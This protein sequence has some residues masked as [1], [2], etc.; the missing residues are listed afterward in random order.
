MA[1]IS[2]PTC[3]KHIDKKTSYRKLVPFTDFVNVV[4]QPSHRCD[5]DSC[6]VFRHNF[7]KFFS[8]E[9]RILVIG[10]RVFICQ[11][12]SLFVGFMHIECTEYCT[13]DRQELLGRYP[14]HDCKQ[15]ECE[16]Y[17]K[18]DDVGYADWCFHIKKVMRYL[19][20]LLRLSQEI[21]SAFDCQNPLH[22]HPRKIS[23]IYQAQQ[24]DKVSRENPRLQ[25]QPRL[26]E[27]TS[28]SRSQ[29]TSRMFSHQRMIRAYKR[30]L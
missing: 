5:S 12:F 4:C 16:C 26:R 18:E 6:C 19:R 11:F 30:N 21:R 13:N 3:K 22:R 2:Y 24:A 29:F 9:H 28:R 10:S 20:L 14:S 23:F 7:N 17:H 8:F 1:E 25:V 15:T 27:F